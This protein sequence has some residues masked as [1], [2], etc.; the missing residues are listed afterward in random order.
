MLIPWAFFQVV[1]IGG[2]YNG[3]S[4][5][6]RHVLVVCVVFVS[7]MIHT[8]LELVCLLGLFLPSLLVFFL[9]SFLSFQSIFL[10]VEVFAISR[11][12]LSFGR[13]IMLFSLE[14]I[15]R[16]LGSIYSILLR[17]SYSLK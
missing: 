5:F 10:P 13:L 17:V 2:H 11:R 4:N 1:L 8:H 14:L 12:E 9:S 6:C 7:M 3:I 15:F 16:A